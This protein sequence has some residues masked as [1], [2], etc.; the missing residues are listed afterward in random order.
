MALLSASAATGALVFLPMLAWLSRAGDWRPAVSAV[1]IA[2]SAR[3]PLVA[4]LIPEHPSGAGTGQL[5]ETPASQ[6]A[7]PVLNRHRQRRWRSSCSRAAPVSQC[8]GCCSDQTAAMS[9]R[10]TRG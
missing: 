1:K 7:A 8:S 9:G 2:C 5:G 10:A 3:L 4:F 6:S